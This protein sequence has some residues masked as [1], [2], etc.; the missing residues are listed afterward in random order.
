[1]RILETIE[2]V[3]RN[4][5]DFDTLRAEAAACLGVALPHLGRVEIADSGSGA[6]V[7]LRWGG[8]RFAVIAVESEPLH[9]TDRLLLEAV[10]AVLVDRWARDHAATGFAT[11][12]VVGGGPVEPGVRPVSAP[13]HGSSTYAFESMD[14]LE[15]YL[16]HQERDFIYTRWGNP[17]VRAAEVG[18]PDGAGRRGDHRPPGG[19]RGS[20]APQ[21]RHGRHC[22]RA[23]LPGGRR[24]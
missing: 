12:A 1:M 16:E 6:A 18:E 21:F 4:A 15:A 22:Q 7:P 13:V 19:S 24:R 20:R 11:R 9:P 14:A 5:P 17:T 3:A 10:A 8:R 2:Q 23:A